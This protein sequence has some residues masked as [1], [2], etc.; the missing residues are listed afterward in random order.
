MINIEF[1][2]LLLYRQDTMTND[3]VHRES[4]FWFIVPVRVHIPW[5]SQHQVIREKER[6]HPQA[7]QTT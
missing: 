6:S 7:T 1:I 2:S 3:T 5:Q 4:L